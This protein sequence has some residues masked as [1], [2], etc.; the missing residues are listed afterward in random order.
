[1]GDVIQ[2]PE[3]NYFG[4]CPK[5]GRT[6]GYLNIGCDHWFVCDRHKTKWYIGSN[7]F[8][9]WKEETPETWLKNQD[10]LAY[11]REVKPLRRSSQSEFEEGTLAPE[12][13]DPLP[14]LDNDIP[15]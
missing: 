13:G 8:S 4:D 14:E 6:D 3:A 7:L 15:F 5:C 1:M 10:K 2:L 9:C 11:H 12:S